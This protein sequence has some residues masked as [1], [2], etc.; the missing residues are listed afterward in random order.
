MKSATL[1]LPDGRTLDYRIRQ[2]ARAK[3]LRMQYSFDKGL[4]V[5]QP[6]GCCENQLATWI[7]SKLDWVSKTA[8]NAEEQ[9]RQRIQAAAETELQRPE[10]LELKA[11]NQR[12]KVKYIKTDSVQIVAHY[13]ESGLLTL[14]GTT[15]NIAFC[16]RVLQKW[17]QNHARY[18]LGVL[19]HKL[20]QETRFSYNDYRVK[21]QKTCWGSC[22]S[23]GN[24]N[25]NYKL[26]LMPAEW[27]RYTMLHE[28]CHTEE[29]NHSKRFWTQVEQHMPD[30]Q[31]IHQA[32]KTAYTQLPAWANYRF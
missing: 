32:M 24:I 5:T 22:S 25:L 30:Y 8:T 23:R 29:M 19:L 1:T 6:G 17:T 18:H 28:L 4:I 16:V 13:E 20:A 11:I 21:D 31:P 9:A 7:D 2:S 26:L 12:I 14:S 27:A 15:E 10:T 3:Y